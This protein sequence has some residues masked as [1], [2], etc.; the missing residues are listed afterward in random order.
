M[1]T[2]N[3][4]PSH[5][6]SDA[7]SGESHPNETIRLLLERSSCRSFYPEKIPDDVLQL[8]FEAGTHAPT[9]G[10][11]QPF[12]IIRIDDAA[13]KSTLS[14]LCGDQSFIASAPTDLLFCIDWYRLRRWAEIEKAPFAATSSFRHFW[15]SFQDTVIAAQ[16][17]CTAADALGLGSVYV[18]TV[19]ECFAE[20]RDMLKLPDGVFPVVLLCLGYPKERP[21]PKRK[22]AA[23]I[24]VHNEKYRRYTDEELLSA[25]SDK[26]QYPG[27]GITDERLVEMERVCR[28]VHG[29]DFAGECL[30]RIRGRGV[31]NVAQRYFGLHYTADVMAEG[32]D[33]FIRIMQDFGFSWLRKYEPMGE[34]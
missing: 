28:R 4:E 15:I 23:S 32:N 8:V 33:E 27:V 9:G 3:T 24:I 1:S 2:S 18:G 10:N 31:I 30:A 26:Y 5:H 29:P 13:T 12:S 19:T 7:D 17:M 25:Y 22:L 21:R 34:K 14:H 6:G 11:L 16:N 20:L